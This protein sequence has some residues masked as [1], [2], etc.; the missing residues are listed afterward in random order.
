MLDIA[1]VNQV[2]P[3]EGTVGQIEGAAH[4]LFDHAPQCA[5]FQCF[6]KDCFSEC[7]TGVR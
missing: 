4:F 6:G 5:G 3:D 2:Y 7:Q 1:Q